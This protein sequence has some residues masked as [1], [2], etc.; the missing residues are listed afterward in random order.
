LAA[1]NKEIVRELLRH[2]VLPVSLLS[3][4]I[5]GAG[6]FSLPFVFVQ[7]GWVAAVFYLLLF[8]VVFTLIHVMYADLLLADGEHDFVG[9]ARRFLGAWAGH[10]AFLMTVLGMI[11]ALTVYLVL[12]L[13]FS[14]ILL[15]HLDRGILIVLFWVL[16]SLMM[17]FPVRGQALLEALAVLVILVVVGIVA[18]K[19]FAHLERLYAVKPLGMGKIFLPFGPVLFSYAG[20]V[21]IPSLVSYF[22]AEKLSFQKLKSVIFWGTAL[23]GFVYLIFA[24][25]VVGLS[26]IVSEDSISGIADLSPAF[27][28][29]I[30]ILVLAS[31]L[32]SYFMVGVS[33]KRILEKDLNLKRLLAG[34]IVV[35][36]PLLLYVAGLKDFLTLVSI[37]GGIFIALEGIFIALMWE[38]SQKARASFLLPAQFNPAVRALVIVF[39]LGAIYEIIKLF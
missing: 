17:F 39:V 7:S 15:P 13:S 18:F 37:A 33:I 5:I 28:R 14:S 23:P 34:A 29:V 16:G 10:L 20:R 11:F 30:G 35:F 22:K 26:N 8:G 36:A 6:I 38:K 27:L 1:D 24:L 21:A 19:G 32:S 25:G 2:C 9:F 4:T 3:G 31:L 12:S